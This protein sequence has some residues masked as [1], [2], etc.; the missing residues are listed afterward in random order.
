MEHHKRMQH[1]GFAQPTFQQKPVI[2]VIVGN[3]D[4][5]ERRLFG[6]G[7]GLTLDSRP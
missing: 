5:I 3:Q 1:S 4:G 6:R 7:D 2:W